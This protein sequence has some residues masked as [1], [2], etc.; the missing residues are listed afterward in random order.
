MPLPATI[1]AAA[2]RGGPL[3]LLRG[4]IRG[5]AILAAI[6]LAAP[7]GESHAAAVMAA[8]QQ[9]GYAG[10]MLEKVGRLWSPPEIGRTAS[11]RVRVSVDGRGRL[12][13]CAVA[14]ASGYPALDA[15][16]CAAVRQIGD[17]GMPP[18][19][20]PIDVHLSFWTGT[21]HAGRAG[22]AAS[23]AAP[24]APAQAA[25]APAKAAP[26]QAPAPAPAPQKAPAPAAPAATGAAAGAAT[27][28]ATPPPASAPA[29]QPAAITGQ[30]QDSYGPKY[31]KYFSNVVWKLRNAIIIPAE[32]RPGTY[33]V[34]VRL[35]V[36]A[37]GNMK[38]QDILVGSGD[39]RLDRNVLRGL[40]RAG[41]V[42]PPPEGLGHT[43]DVTLSLKR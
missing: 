8:D 7:A 23:P 3:P 17:F 16:A 40:K 25:A 35:D 4:G 30:A 18:Y 37:A 38:S 12:V 31:R 33:K 20:M 24:A 13:T 11:A 6:L 34:T 41:S 29:A 36:D 39:A 1:P 14:K 21:P 9:D 26:A 22:D 15:S 5:L 19:G 10:S 32:I 28:A 27:A 2:H 42:P 43:L